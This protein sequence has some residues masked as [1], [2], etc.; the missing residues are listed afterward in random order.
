MEKIKEKNDGN[1]KY[2][3]NI[4]CLKDGDIILTHGNHFVSKIIVNVTKQPFSHASI[5]EGLSIIEATR[6]GVFSMNPHL[7]FLH[8]SPKR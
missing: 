1:I 8:H 4:Q 7:C 2:I 5:F 6:K 3:L